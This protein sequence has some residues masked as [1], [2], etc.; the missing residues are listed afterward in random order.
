MRVDLHIHTI[1]SSDGMV[2]PETILNGA[3]EKNVQIISIT[4][5]ANVEAIPIISELA[6][7][8]Q[9]TV[10]SG[11]ELTSFEDVE[12]HILGYGFDIKHPSII[13]IINTVSDYRKTNINLIIDMLRDMGIIIGRNEYV[14]NGRKD[15]AN[16]LLKKGL[17]T[18]TSQAFELF[19]D[20]KEYKKLPIQYITP[21]EAIDTINKA[22]GKAVLA[23]PFSVRRD[24]D[25]LFNKIK[26]LVSYGLCGIEA[27]YGQY[28]LSDQRNLANIADRLK[29]FKTSGSDFHG[30]GKGCRIYFGDY[31]LCD[32]AVKSTL[33][34]VNSF[35]LL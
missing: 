4:D 3:I 14:I 2:N 22:G 6:V 28:N 26:K 8:K 25:E 1:F 24:Y 11:I 21:E 10:I 29:I 23:H 33:D 27:Y 15:I 13:K 12:Q 34:F 16:I 18:N 9:I 19:L 5:H 35:K 31:I 30:E 7:S 32:D 20:G 17:V